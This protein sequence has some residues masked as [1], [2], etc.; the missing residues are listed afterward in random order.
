M[1]SVY[2]QRIM[3]K[4]A[5]TSYE[6]TN[7][8]QTQFKPNQSQF[9]PNQSQFKPNSNPIK[10]NFKYRPPIMG[11]DCPISL[12]I[13]PLIVYNCSKSGDLGHEVKL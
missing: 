10:A 6:K 2:V 13:A 7:P 4:N 8:K 12:S 9:K 3:K 1:Q 5:D 11:T